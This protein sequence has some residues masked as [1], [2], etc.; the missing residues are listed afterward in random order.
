MK[1]EIYTDELGLD[2]HEDEI[3]GVDEEIRL[4]HGESIGSENDDTDDSNDEIDTTV[5]VNLILDYLRQEL[6]RPEYLRIPLKFKYKGKKY[7][8]TPLKEINSNR[9]I[10]LVNG[11]MEAINLTAIEPV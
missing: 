5:N 1:K 11:K 2:V 6:H 7:S 9:F 10:F 8:G 3:L 4:N